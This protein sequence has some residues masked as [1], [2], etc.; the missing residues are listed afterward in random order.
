MKSQQQQVLEYLETNWELRLDFYFRHFWFLDQLAFLIQMDRTHLT[1]QMQQNTPKKLRKR[2]INGFYSFSS[3]KYFLFLYFYFTFLN[4]IQL[5]V[6]VVSGQIRNLFLVIA[7]M[8]LISFLL[9]AFCLKNQPVM[10]P[11]IAEY[12]RRKT[13]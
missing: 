10:P 11:S 7:V 13:G 4:V 8:C 6:D 1:G 3:Q 5:A 2:L 12:N 9:V